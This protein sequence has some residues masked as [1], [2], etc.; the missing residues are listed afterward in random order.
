MR[1]AGHV[2]WYPV[3][4][5]AVAGT[6]LAEPV[7]VPGAAVPGLLGTPLAAIRLTDAAGRPIPFQIDEL[8][9]EGEYVCPEGDEPNSALSN[10]VLDSA[11]ELVFMLEDASPVDSAEQVQAGPATRL[12]V[13]DAGQA[14]AVLVHGDS[15]IPLSPARYLEYAARE[16]RLATPLYTATFGRDRFH[17]TQA[18]VKHP[19]SSRYVML[20]SELRIEIALR[21]F[22]GLVPVR[23][24]EESIYCYV[25]RYKAGPV[26]LIRRGDFHL[27]LGLGIKGSR[28]TVNQICYPDVVVVP[29]RVH[30]PV[31]FR[32]FF[33][34]AY[35][36]MT[37]VLSDAARGAVFAVPR[38]GLSAL[39]PAGAATDTLMAAAPDS[40]LFR[41]E[42]AGQGYGWLLTTSIGRDW[43]NGSGYALASPSPRGGI[44]HCG[45]RLSLTDLPRGY[46]RITNWVLFSRD[47]PAGLE[48]MAAAIVAPC[49][50]HTP[51][52]A[53][54][55]SDIAGR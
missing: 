55:R 53:S 22:W 10:G 4:L 48:R 5:L 9:G 27:K 45:Y 43:L 37:P 40:T 51:G 24:T 47:I 2:A 15:S 29:V 13:R 44:G 50:V 6:A 41:V 36:E 52:G 20:A 23:Y 38:H 28:A 19:D 7:V 3:L 32:S 33:R 30:L 42:R 11:D 12:L 18:G 54:L 39:L 16:E 46:Y 49:R 34:D 8:L 35:I 1:A 21:A 17:F 14:R 26:R 25:K 31:R